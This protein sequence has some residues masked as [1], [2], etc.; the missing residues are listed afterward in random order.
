MKNYIFVLFFGLCAALIA[1]PPVN[2][3]T[4]NQSQPN[5]TIMDT[6][7]Y[8]L[9]STN[10]GDIK[11]RLYDE[12]PQHKANFLKIIAD[13]VLDST[14]FHRVIPEFMI[15]GGDPNSKTAIAGQ[16]LG[17][18]G[19]DY[20]VPAEFDKN[21]IHKRGALAAARDGNPQKASSSCQFYIV[22]GRT[23]TEDELNTLAQRSGT[24]WT[25][26]QKEIY[27]T[28]GG[29]PFLDMGYTVFGEVV[30]G[31]GVVDAICTLSRDPS[32]R[33]YQ[34]IRMRVAVLQQK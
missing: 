13:G 31:M 12:T 33:P 1:M 20:R 26:E 8:V 10:L 15:Q 11:I 25:A 7:T 34:D 18:G 23:Y 30:D 29:A 19:L 9:I 27:K 5:N 4:A 21:L 3:L 17:S 16:H 28:S 2:K 6:S 14:L 24:S 32:D 22:Q